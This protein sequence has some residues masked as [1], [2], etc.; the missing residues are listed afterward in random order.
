MAQPVKKKIQE[1]HP[2][3]MTEK[4]FRTLLIDGTSLL[5]MCFKDDTR[6]SD[7]VH[8]G[9]VYQFLS[10]LRKQFEKVDPA[11]CYVF[12]DDEYSGW[13]RWE[14]YP[15]YKAN[16]DKKYD[17]Y[18]TS[19][20]MKMMNERLKS[21]REYLFSK[22][23]NV[24]KTYEDPFTK[25]VNENFTRERAILMKYFEELYIRCYMDEICE[26]DD[27]ISYYCLNKKKNEQIVIVSGDMDLLQLLSDDICM[28]ELH[29]KKYIS[30]K[31]FKEQ[32]G[33]HYSN[34]F[35]KKVLCGDQSDNIGHI[36]GLSETALFEMMPEIEQKPITVEDVIDRAKQLIEERKESKKKPLKLHEN[37]VN[38]VT[39]STYDGDFYEINKKII[40]L[41][42]PLLTDDAKETM[43]SMI[44]A[45]IDPDD[46][47]FKNL[48]TYILEDKIEKLHSDTVFSEFFSPFKRLEVKEKN[49][50]DLAQKN[51][52]YD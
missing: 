11:Y 32:F 9:G 17:E 19:E 23:K 13:K 39:T 50:F 34:I 36:R 52:K 45:P 31:N 30:V 48:Y 42:S 1:I 51:L 46:R 37:I 10:Q 2:N 3:L 14:L 28:Y 27:L 7:G 29:K 49:R 16:R 5:M 43:D 18:Q 22:K 8:Y 41:K 4:P 15:L 26:G 33:Y 35:V 6:N 47:S 40:D 20:Y 25:L 21:M 44:H 38:A 12:F 24:K